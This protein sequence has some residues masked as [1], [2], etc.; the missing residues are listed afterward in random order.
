MRSYLGSFQSHTSLSE[1]TLSWDVSTVYHQAAGINVSN[2][3]H[4]A[5]SDVAS[6]VILQLM[7]LEYLGPRPF[8]VMVGSVF[9]E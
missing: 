6:T 8:F 5:A 7:R 9:R 4:G 2:K 3:Y 1:N